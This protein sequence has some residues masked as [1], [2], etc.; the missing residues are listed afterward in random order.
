M[1]MHCTIPDF[2]EAEPSHFHPEEDDPYTL[3]WIHNVASDL[4][5]DGL[6]SIPIFQYL[7]DHCIATARRKPVQNL[8]REEKGL[9]LYM[10]SLTGYLRDFPDQSRERGW[11]GNII[12]PP[13]KSLRVGLWGYMKLTTS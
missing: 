11:L 12:Y 2:I 13:P 10:A 8:R 1:P 4:P 9:F 7:N 3:V 5:K 6:R